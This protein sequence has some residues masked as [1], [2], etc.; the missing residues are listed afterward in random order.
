[1]EMLFST[2]DFQEFK[3]KENILKN[4]EYE[5][6][7]KVNNSKYEI[8]VDKNIYE[9]SRILLKINNSNTKNETTSY[10]E[11]QRKDF[12]YF[13]NQ[14]F[15]IKYFRLVFV[16]LILSLMITIIFLLKIIKIHG[17][18]Q[19]IEIQDLYQ[20]ILFPFLLSFIISQ[21]IFLSTR[22]YHVIKEISEIFTFRIGKRINHNSSI[23]KIINFL[24]A[25]IGN[26]VYCIIVLLIL[27]KE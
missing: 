13:A 22:Y 7:T 11:T 5:F 1:M 2:K 24:L 15:N 9:E 6:S 25:I 23:F 10:N 18:K 19:L 17:F 8:F 4:S 26:I 27:L 12:L 16:S 21:V 14:F 3:E 20:F